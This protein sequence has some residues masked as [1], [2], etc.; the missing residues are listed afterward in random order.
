M[1]EPLVETR[2][3]QVQRREFQE[4]ARLGQ[5]RSSACRSVA[6]SSG[7]NSRTQAAQVALPWTGRRADPGSCYEK[8]SRT[9]GE[10]GSALATLIGDGRMPLFSLQKYYPS[11]SQKSRRDMRAASRWKVAWQ[12]RKD[13]TMMAQGWDIEEQP[14]VP[15][16]RG[17]K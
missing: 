11:F 14:S 10:V 2:P 15:S 3:V 6:I 5:G 17:N 13:G 7:G 12:G 9:M 4:F 1:L 16:G 8:D